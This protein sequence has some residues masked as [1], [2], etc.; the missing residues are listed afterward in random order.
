MFS[1][2]EQ[3]ELQALPHSLAEKRPT[4]A[5]ATALWP[6]QERAPILEGR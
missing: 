3:G 6:A 4:L 2:V 1:K 5:T